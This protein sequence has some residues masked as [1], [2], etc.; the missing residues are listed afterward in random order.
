MTELDM[1]V[2]VSSIDFGNSVVSEHKPEHWVD[3]RIKGT[4][5]DGFTARRRVFPDGQCEVS[6]CADKHFL[7]PA[8]TPQ[9]RA[10]RG[11]SEKRE[12]NNA[13]AG[14]AAKK[15]VRHRCKALGADRMVTLTY[16]ENMTDRAEALKHWDLF[17]RRLKKAGRFDY[18]AVIEQQERGSIHFHIAVQGRQCYVL[19]RSIWQSILGK[20]ADGRQMGQVNVREPHKFGFGVKGNHKLASYI[21]KYCGKEMLSRVPPDFVGPI[22]PMRVLDE[23]RYFSSRGIPI[24]VVESWRLH[25]VT[26]M[27]QAARAA[28]D[29]LAGHSLAGLDTWCNNPLGV[30]YLASEPGFVPI[31]DICP[32]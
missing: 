19:L 2:A 9:T 22:R 15:A 24:P 26:N 5:Q 16:R 13:D 11:E 14:R 10:K 18:V 6:V 12:Q 8:M 32:F 25:G 30:V 17:R 1:E 21:A 3:D 27:L 29:A 7:G 28:F 20:D 4:W 23:K 31:E